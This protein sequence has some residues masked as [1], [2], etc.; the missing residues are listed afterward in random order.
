MAS[1]E[2]LLANKFAEDKPN[3]NQNQQ[4]NKSNVTFTI[5]DPKNKQ[6]VNNQS[7]SSSLVAQQFANNPKNKT[8]ND[9]KDQFNNDGE[10][11]ADYLNNTSDYIPGE[12]TKAGMKELSYEQNE[13]GKWTKVLDEL[14]YVAKNDE[15]INNYINGLTNKE[16]G[17][18]NSPKAEDSI[19]KYEQKLV[20]MGAAEYDTNGKFIMKPVG[21]G[22]ETLATLLS[23]GLSVVGLAI[24]IPIIPINF[25]KLTGKE[26]K[27]AQ[28][29]ELQKQYMAIKEANAA[30]LEDVKSSNDAGKFYNENEDN[31]ENYAKYTEKMGAYKAKAEA[32]VN[33]AEKLAGI[34]VDKEGKLIDKRTDAQI[35]EDAAKF[36][37]QLALL[38]KDQNFK[39]KYADL[40]QNHAKEMAELQSKLATGQAIDLMKYQNTGFIKDLQEMRLKPK[41]IAMYMAAKNGISTT[42]KVVGYITNLGSTAANF[43]PGK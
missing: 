9:L 6:P 21:K 7:K 40:E 12:K 27:D 25:K 13:Q 43:I 19:N 42:D 30:K 20:E 23:V 8:W 18:V 3:N 31:I 35:R 26:E 24:G 5:D 34:E 4:V 29:Q 2:S 14:E 38:E 17:E 1:K 32:D 41:D 10:K 22:W 36:K 11:I 16:T 28:I 33:K 39:L 37:Q 15:N